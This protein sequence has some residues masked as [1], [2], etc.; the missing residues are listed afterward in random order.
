MLGLHDEYE[1]DEGDDFDAELE[2]Q[3]TAHGVPPVRIHVLLRC[4]M[5]AD[6]A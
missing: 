1:G 2:A 6:G 3:A 4:Y 5:L